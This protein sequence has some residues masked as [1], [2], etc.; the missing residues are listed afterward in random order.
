MKIYIELGYYFTSSS[1]SEEDEANLELPV[2]Y[3]M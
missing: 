1:L 2:G 3:F